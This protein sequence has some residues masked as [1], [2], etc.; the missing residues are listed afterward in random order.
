MIKRKYFKRSVRQGLFVAMCSSLMFLSA[1][2]DSSKQESSD[3]QAGEASTDET[4]NENAEESAIQTEIRLKKAQ[5]EDAVQRKMRD[6]DSM[7][8]E[9]WMPAEGANGK[10]GTMN[11]WIRSKNGFGGFAKGKFLCSWDENDEFL[12]AVPI[13]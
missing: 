7:V 13:E 5:C 9:D 12:G 6:P 4:A 10:L 2:A 3:E 11:M 8:V 1:C